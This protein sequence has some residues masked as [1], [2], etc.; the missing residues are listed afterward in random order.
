MSATNQPFFDDEQLI[1]LVETQGRGSGIIKLIL[2]NLINRPEKASRLK[3]FKNPSNSNMFKIEQKDIVQGFS[4][5]T[6]FVVAV[7]NG[8]CTDNATDWSNYTIL[9]TYDLDNL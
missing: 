3:L 4:N 6:T 5:P 9:E 2:Q 8:T 7:Y 1:L